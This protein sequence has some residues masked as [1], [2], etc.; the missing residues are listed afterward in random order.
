MN[1]Y[2]RIIIVLIFYFFSSICFSQDYLVTKKNDTIYGKVEW[3]S[4][5]TVYIEN[6]DGKQRFRA[7]E[8]KSFNR[9][10]FKFSSV[11]TSIPEFLLEVKKGNISYY[12]ESHLKSRFTLNYV[13]Q[14]FLEYNDKI[15]PIDVDANIKGNAFISI[16]TSGD[17]QGAGHFELYS[18]NFKWSLYHILGK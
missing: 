14:I 8:T 16:N 9:G 4:N 15:Y 6:K 12:K 18:K 13:R 3:K 2:F 10:D 11:K 7:N 5:T 17:I 1:K